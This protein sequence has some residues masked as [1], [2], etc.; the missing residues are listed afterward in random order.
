MAS[1]A[2][3]INMYF[4]TRRS[5]AMGFAMTVTGLGPVF[6]PLLISLAMREYGARATALLLGALSL[7]SAVGALLLHPVRWHMVKKGELQEGARRTVYSV[8]TECT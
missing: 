5:M 4:T 6:M 1:F 2:Y 8:R 3:A 7:H